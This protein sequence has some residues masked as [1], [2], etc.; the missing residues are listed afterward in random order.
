MN[1]TAIT[2]L[3]LSVCFLCLLS[4][5]SR[6]PQYRD[7]TFTATSEA[8]HYGFAIAH[9]TLEDNEIK[10]VYLEEYT[11]QGRKKD[12]ETYPYQPTAQG[13]E[14]MRKRFIEENSAEV[15]LYTGSTHSSQKYIDAVEKALAIALKD[16][17]KRPSGTY[18]DGTYMG[19]S[20]SDERSWAVVWVTLEEDRIVDLRLEQV[21]THN[22]QFFNWETYPYEPV[23]EAREKL[24]EAFMEAN[25]ADV[26]IIEGATRSSHRWREAVDNALEQARIPRE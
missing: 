3:F 26:D 23:I 15:D 18:F 22:H 4:A 8:D 16:A 24:R 5:C 2:I 20:D 7:G 19:V 1:R 12:M 9:V 6:S 25:A 10:D 21:D 14:T 13:M 11:G 17:D